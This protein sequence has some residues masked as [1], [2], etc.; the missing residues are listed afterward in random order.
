MLRAGVP[1][2]LRR[3]YTLD[4]DRD[5]SLSVVWCEQAYK[6]GSLVWRLRSGA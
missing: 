6:P 4:H 3:L 2:S 5:M 1:S